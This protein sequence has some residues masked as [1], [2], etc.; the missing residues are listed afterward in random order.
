M[1][2]P[3]FFITFML[4]LTSRRFRTLQRN[5]SDTICKLNDEFPSTYL[6]VL[7][8]AEDHRSKFHF[9]IDQLSFFRILFQYIRNGS[10]Q[11]GSTIEQQL[12]RTITGNYEKSLSRKCIE[13]LLAISISSRFDK[14]QI[15]SAYLQV[16]YLGTNIIGIFE[17]A[18]MLNLDLNNDAQKLAIEYSVRLKYPEPSKHNEI[19][20]KNYNRRKHHVAKLVEKQVTSALRN[21]R[22]T[23][24]LRSFLANF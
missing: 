21:G 2:A 5:V 15:A 4:F 18:K 9:G 19:W 20:L 3:Y 13:Q 1:S 11:G 23:L 22:K 12:V 10:K 8:A 24:G 16:A 14:Y 7:Q 17:L 6:Y